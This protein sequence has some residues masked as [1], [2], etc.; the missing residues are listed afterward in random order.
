MGTSAP[1]N[2]P[3][4]T[5]AS[6]LEPPDLAIPTT[7]PTVQEALADICHRLT[8]ALPMAE[9]VGVVVLPA[10]AAP[11]SRRRT[12]DGA[13]VISTAP[14][15][16]AVIEVERQVDEG[17]VLTACRSRTVVTSGD[18]AADTRWRRFGE[19][20]LELRMLSVLSVPLPDHAGGTAGVLSLYSQSRN[21]FDA[22][23]HDLTAAIACVIT[24]ALFVAE[25]AQRT[26]QE[27]D[28]IS[29]AA[30]RAAIVNQAVGVLIRVNCT[31]EQAR[32]RLARMAKRYD[33]D[34]AEAARDIVAEAQTEAHLDFL[35]S[36]RH[37]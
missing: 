35:L 9:S 14:A 11:A 26:R 17:P 33:Q 18:L 32:A 12:L 23:A 5:A 37:S 13:A 20:I 27:F 19:A 31:E 25:M 1:M 2:Q 36:R 15:A 16:E 22:H 28:R 10:D 24:N 6:V 7:W 34:V 30:E 29:E 8:E 4:R 21:A 3:E